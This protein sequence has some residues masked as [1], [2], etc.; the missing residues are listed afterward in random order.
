MG[1]VLPIACCAAIYSL[2]LASADWIDFVTG[3]V[4]GAGVTWLLRAF[5]R[6]T[7]TVALTDSRPPI[8]RRVVWFPIFVS[9]VFRDIV[10]GTIDVAKYS[11][12]MRES[13]YQGIVAVPIGERTRSGVAI[14]AWATTISPGTALV[15]V[16]WEGGQMLIH[17]MD[18][19]DPE[20]VRSVHQRFYERYQRQVFP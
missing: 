10:L 1:W 14:S 13:D 8:W 16:D 3:L 12:G 7:A 18:A 9:A 17:V 19:R 6:E 2:T 11:L 5:M 20:R 4:I 15:D